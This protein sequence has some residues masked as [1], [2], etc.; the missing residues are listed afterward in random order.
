MENTKRAQTNDREQ[1]NSPLIGIVLLFGL[2]MIGSL[3]VFVFGS[4]M[5]DTLQSEANRER[6]QQY[7][8]ETD[9]R[10][11]TVAAAGNEQR[12]PIDE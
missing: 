5:L 6:A 4:A 11:M 8:L 3:L 12:L 7:M 10:I 2:V 9:Q 1:A